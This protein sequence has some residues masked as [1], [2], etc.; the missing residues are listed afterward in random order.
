MDKKQDILKQLTLLANDKKAKNDTFR[1]RAY[2]KAITAIKEHKEEIIS[3]KDLDNI[4]GLAKGSIREKII[5]YI[6]TGNIKEI[7]KITNESTIIQTLSNIYG[8]GPAKSNELV[9][10]HNITSIEDLRKNQELLNDKQKI[11]LKYYE[12]LLKR[13]PKKEMIKHD[14]FITDFINLIDKNDDLIY[15]IV[16]SYRREANNSGDI[17]VLCTTKNKDIQLF[18]QII[19]NLENDKYITETLAKGDKK[20]MGICK[21]PRYKTNRRLDMIYT[22][23]KNY[24]F[25][26]LYFTG[27]GQF[28][29]DM[30]NYALSLG[31]SLNEYGLKY[32]KGKNKDKFV[33]HK[34]ETEKDIFKF[35]NI[36]YIEPK[37]R[38]GG[39]L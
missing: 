37:D 31:Y 1:Y 7:E 33:D 32:L 17:D 25:T 9:N 13:I 18:N 15:E 4:N 12:D 3:V 35:L 28:N 30:R 27:S 26:L 2:I 19:E 16:G 29:I 21:L 23:Y 38:K 6:K 14:E 24:P 34:F 20:F 39:L 8:I 11:G 10:K 22:D 36:D 5:E